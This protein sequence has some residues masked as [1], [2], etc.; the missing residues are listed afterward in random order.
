MILM[1]LLIVFLLGVSILLGAIA[2]NWAASK[3]GLST[4]YDFVKKPSDTSAISLVWLFVIYPLALGAI[5]YFAGKI[6]PN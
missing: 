3:F 4:W 5:A 2:L 1:K 6:L